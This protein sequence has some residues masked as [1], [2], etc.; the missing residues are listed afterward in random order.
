MNEKLIERIIKIFEEDEEL[1]EECIEQLDAYNGYL[2]DDRFYPMEELE[3]LLSNKSPLDLLNM[4]YFGRD[5]EYWTYDQ[6]GNKIYPH[7][8]NPNRNYF[9]FNGYGNLCSCDYKDY[10]SHL[11]KWVIESMVENR[12]WV[13]AIDDN[14]EL[15][16]L[17]DKLEEDQE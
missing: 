10:S 9:Y 4:G 15:S 5:E 16:E 7:S 13:D 1:F 11:D 14:E 2:G 6:S 12:Y 17:F 3:E 8:F